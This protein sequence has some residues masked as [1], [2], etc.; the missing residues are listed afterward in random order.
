MGCDIHLVL[1]ERDDAGKW[2]G[3]NTFQ[4]HANVYRKPNEEAR[5]WPVAAERNCQRF[6]RLANVF[7]C[8]LIPVGGGGFE[9]RGIPEN[10]SETTRH[11]VAK[12]GV[13]GHHHSWLPVTEAVK[14]FEETEWWLPSD[15]FDRET[16]FFFFFNLD[17]EYVDSHR[18]VFWFV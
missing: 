7:G 3:V 12:D 17:I 18:I 10:A 5:S 6:D 8:V 1:E 2:I 4:S 14:I 11:L 15:K 13:D 16:P 9:P